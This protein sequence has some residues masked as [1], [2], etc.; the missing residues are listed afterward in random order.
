MHS[1]DVMLMTPST[2]LS[3][4]KTP[5]EQTRKAGFQVCGRSL[6]PVFNWER[7][8]PSRQRCMSVI[9]A[10]FSLYCL[11]TGCFQASSKKVYSRG[12]R[13]TNKY[14]YIH[15]YM[16]T[17]THTHTYSFRKTISGNRACAQLK[18]LA[19]LDDHDDEIELLQIQHDVISLVLKQLIGFLTIWLAWHYS[20]IR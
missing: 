19:L 3:S 11:H 7:N 1:L 12:C 20:N 9:Q 10:S 16:H 5:E 2:L 14:T 4:C 13:K 15:T 18:N 6:R 17:H 8:T